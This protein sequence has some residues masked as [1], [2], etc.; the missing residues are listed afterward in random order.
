MEG[1]TL[2]EVR[3]MLDG[4]GLKLG[5][6]VYRN[7]IAKDVV[8]GVSSKG[9]S[10]RAGSVLPKGAKVDLILGDGFGAAE[11]SVP[12]LTGLSREEAIFL[13]RGNSLFLGKVSYEGVISD[14]TKVKVI[15]QVPS[16]DHG[17]STTIKQGSMVDII[18]SQEE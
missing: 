18:L 12:D 11:I 4:F 6:M 14:S 15:R 7:D 2:T 8:L 5:E 16:S 10:L 13:L 3:A 9:K 17:D 1:K